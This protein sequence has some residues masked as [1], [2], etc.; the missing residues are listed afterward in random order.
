MDFSA[1]IQAVPALAKLGAGFAAS[2]KDYPY[3][4][5]MEQAMQ[6]L[7]NANAYTADAMNPNSANFKNV[8]EG[9]RLAGRLNL[10][11]AIR[12]IISQNNIAAAKGVGPVS[13]NP[14]RR[15]ETVWR[16]LTRGY[17]D[18]RTAARNRARAFLLNAA[19]ASRQNAAGYSPLMVM[20]DRVNAFNRASSMG[21]TNA[22]MTGLGEFAKI[23]PDMFGK[24]DNN[25]TKDRAP[26]FRDIRKDAAGRILGGI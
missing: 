17:L 19:R 21:G 22:L 8:E 3:P 24:S 10:I 1:L 26:A 5:G 7:V 16:A 15:D 23:L 14:E 18:N 2:Q 13:I 6:A 4:A 12:T 25:L 9:E 20:G 11:D